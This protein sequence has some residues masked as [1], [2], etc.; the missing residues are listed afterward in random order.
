MMRFKPTYSLRT[1]NLSSG[2][3]W[4]TRTGCSTEVA[5]TILLKA[6]YVQQTI[7]LLQTNNETCPQKWSGSLS[8][9]Q[10]AYNSDYN[11]QSGL[12]LS[13]WQLLKRNAEELSGQIKAAHS[14]L[15]KQLTAHF[16]IK[17]RPR[18]TCFRFQLISRNVQDQSAPSSSSLL[19][20]HPPSDPGV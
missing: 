1:L 18:S 14:S 6:V 3:I 4:P 17:C 2:S 19:L 13:I 9:A 8:S 16:I 15:S 20:G 7:P 12:I 5:R 11:S 10:G